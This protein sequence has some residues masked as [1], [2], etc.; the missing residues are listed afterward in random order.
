MIELTKKQRE[1]VSK[2]LLDICKLVV[3]ILILG[4]VVSVEG[5]NS[6][7]FLA[8]FFVFLILF[9]LGIIADRGV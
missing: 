8:G 5:F 6:K 9:V 3:A 7:I 2:T 1:N 4:P